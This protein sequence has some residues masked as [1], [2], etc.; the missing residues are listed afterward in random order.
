M[1]ILIIG[2][3]Q[4]VGR[5]VAERALARGHTLTLLN[6]GITNA[7]LFAGVE[8]L[9]GDRSEDLSVLAGHSWDCV[10]DTCG[11]TRKQVRNTCSVLAAQTQHYIFI[12]SVSAYASFET[13]NDETSPT[14]TIEDEDTEVIDGQTYGPL[15]AVCEREVRSAFGPKRS[16]IIR[17]GL[18]V[19]PHDHTDRFTYWVARAARS[20]VM[21]APAPRELLIQFID[22][23][24]L[25][26]WVVHCAEQRT[27]GTF[28]AICPPCR[29][30]LGELVDAACVVTG[31]TAQVSWV[32][33]DFLL[34]HEVAPWTELPLW[35]PGVP[36]SGN[37]P[38]QGDMAGFM[39]NST[40]AAQA[41][42]LI[43]RPLQ[44]TVQSTY[45]WWQQQPPE[46]RAQLKAGL[47][48]EK[49]QAVLAAWQSAQQ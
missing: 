44:D 16:L 37:G 4:F 47:S 28:N 48:A 36:V 45:D 12:S 3:T 23:R 39:S 13:A 38:V 15:K 18:I 10:I 1:Q 26:V 25:A 22:A 11:Y 21:L 5:H 30:T 17:P 33:A 9:H 27:A 32:Q 6:R 34:K 35:I 7:G 24:D 29:N 43:C 40:Q 19:G 20:G 8:Q 2:G 14:G 46:R 42:G 41:A 31:S 49:E